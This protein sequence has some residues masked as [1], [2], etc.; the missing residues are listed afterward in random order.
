MALLNFIQDED[1]LIRNAACDRI[2]DITICHSKE[3]RCKIQPNFAMT[4]MF[5]FVQH[6][7]ACNGTLVKYLYQQLD[8]LY[9]TQVQ[10]L[11]E[12]R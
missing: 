7:M 8:E 9:D 4:S 3:I 6:K 12:S 5:D 2:S 1:E 10:S 11:T